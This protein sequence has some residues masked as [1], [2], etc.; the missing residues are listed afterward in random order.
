M[1]TL[2]TY[3]Q[4]RPTRYDAAGLGCPDQQDWLVC[5]VSIQPKIAECIDESNW[6]AQ[7]AALE[8][9]DQESNDHEVCSFGH[10][11]TGFDIVLVRPGTP[12][13]RC[14]QK[15]AD[16]LENYPLLNEDDFSERETAA[17]YDYVRQ[18]LRSMALVCGSDGE[19]LSDSAVNELAGEI[20]S[21]LAE[22]TELPYRAELGAILVEEKGF[23]HTVEYGWIDV[24]TS[25]AE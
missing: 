1:A 6:D 24:Y 8:A 5:P 12:A 7:L 9:V 11:T 15:L 20:C 19:S 21:E 18:E 22:S 2:I 25:P 14:A 23:T 3:S 16:R 10:W 4:F 13:A 17:Q